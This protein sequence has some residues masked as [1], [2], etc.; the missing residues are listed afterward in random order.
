MMRRLALT[1][2]ILLTV[3]AAPAAIASAPLIERSTVERH[4]DDFYVCDRFNVIGDFTVRRTAMAFADR[5]V[6]HRAIEGT[7][8]NSVTDEAL[9]VREHDVIT[10]YPD[11]SAQTTGEALHVVVPGTGTVIL[12]AGRA[13]F[14][15]EGNA[16]FHGRNDDPLV[17]A[18]LS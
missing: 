9:P 16:T 11:G 13:E 10:F 2:A 17:C 14:D 1:A 4:F 6:I 3:V 5:V 12:I 8:T 18:A 7:L 15:A